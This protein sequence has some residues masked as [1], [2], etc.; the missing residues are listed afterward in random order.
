MEDTKTI[1]KKIKANG[2]ISEVS[3]FIITQNCAKIQIW[4]RSPKNFKDTQRL[5]KK[6]SNTKWVDPN[7]LEHE[8]LIKYDVFKDQGSFA[9]C[10]IWL[11]IN[12]NTYNI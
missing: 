1:G 3:K 10:K 12:S 8:Q 5:D 9:G 6:N 7:T 11:L 2:T 4:F